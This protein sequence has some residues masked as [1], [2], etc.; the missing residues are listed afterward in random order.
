MSPTPP[1]V[2]V[3]DEITAKP[4][5]AQAVLDVYME[6]YAPGARE[7]GMVLDRVLVS[8]PLWL[9]DQPNTLHI[10][11]TVAGAP[12]FWNMSFQGRRNP[13]VKAF[14][15]SIEPLIENR[16]RRFLAAT[17]DLEVLCDV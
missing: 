5:Q 1:P 12:G 2:Y 17:S 6:R 15:D 4:G 13:A 11:W 7:R 14:W 3:L 8:P 9:E 10:S 16:S